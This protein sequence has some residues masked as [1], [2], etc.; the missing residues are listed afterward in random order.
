MTLNDLTSTLK[1][2]RRA[3]QGRIVEGQQGSAEQPFPCYDQNP[4]PA[5]CGND[6]YG[7]GSPNARMNG[8]IKIEG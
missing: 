1:Y 7:D 3:P 4:L 6:R 2:H 5:Y 8:E